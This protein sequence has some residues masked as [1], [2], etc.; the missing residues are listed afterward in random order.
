MMLDNVRRIGFFLFGLSIPLVSQHPAPPPPTPLALRDVIDIVADYEVYHPTIPD[1]SDWYGMTDVDRRKLY[2]VSNADLTARRR[3]TIIQLIRISRRMQ[4]LAEAGHGN[5]QLEVQFQ[6]DQL[7][8]ELF[9]PATQPLPRPPAE[10]DKQPAALAVGE[11]A[12]NY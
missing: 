7:Y 10:P 9:A 2:I 4:G 3:T 8:H 6:A 1:Q 5:E 11:L 12:L